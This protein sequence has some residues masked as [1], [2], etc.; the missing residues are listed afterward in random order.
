MPWPRQVR[1]C[2]DTRRMQL[3]QAA[4]HLENT[5]TS[6]NHTNCSTQERQRVCRNVRL[7]SL[8]KIKTESVEITLTRAS[9]HDFYIIIVIIMFNIIIII[10][11]LIVQMHIH[12]H[13]KKWTFDFSE[14]VSND[15][16]VDWTSPGPVG[17]FRYNGQKNI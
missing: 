11:I 15:I 12:A 1:W 7:K 2:R 4:R 14:M 16:R 17:K 8:P 9:I 6:N 5:T 13:T 10:I 3:L